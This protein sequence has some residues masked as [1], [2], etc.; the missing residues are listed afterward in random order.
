M[1]L[2][3]GTQG[4]RQLRFRH[5]ARQALPDGGARGFPLYR[6]TPLRRR[7]T[8]GEKRRGAVLLPRQRRYERVQDRED[9]GGAGLK[10]VGF[11]T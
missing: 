3:Q 10:I 5:R 7:A 9:R 1:P 8:E 2:P 4:R 11:Q 6:H